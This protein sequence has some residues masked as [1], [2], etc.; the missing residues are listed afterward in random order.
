MKTEATEPTQKKH[1][2]AADTIFEPENPGIGG[3]ATGSELKR[4]TGKI[5]NDLNTWVDDFTNEGTFESGLVMPSIKWDIKQ[6]T[7]R[8]PDMES[9]EFW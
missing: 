1:Y 9:Y 5:L 6:L 8:I 2:Y 4:I 7:A 3:W